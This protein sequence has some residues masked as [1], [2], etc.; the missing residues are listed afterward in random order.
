MLR[1]VVSQ[2]EFEV[3]QIDE[4]LEKYIELIQRS[5]NTTPD[6]VEITALA[7]VLH[8]FYNG[9]E[10]IFLAVAKSV[11]GK[12]PSG[13]QWHRDLLSQMTKSTSERGQVIKGRKG[14]VLG[15]YLAFR[16]FFRHSY[17]FFLDWNELINLVEPLYQVWVEVRGDLEHFIA[18]L[19][20]G[21]N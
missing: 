11:D 13:P 21:R 18:I 20:Q 4:L 15:K 14:Q 2:I 16:H 17:S 6:L 3:R 7:S 12:V 5:L 19:Q 9:L 10:N 8:S 1:K